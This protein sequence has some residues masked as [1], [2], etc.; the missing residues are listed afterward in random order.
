MVSHEGCSGQF[1]NG[2]EIVDKLRRMGFNEQFLPMPFDLECEDCGINFLMDTF[3][4]HCPNC[5]MVYGVTPCHA[6]DP[7]NV[8]A[9]GK[10]Y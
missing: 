2:K 7:A 6:F 5:D 3:E 9:A 1:D 10:A 8:M 4:K